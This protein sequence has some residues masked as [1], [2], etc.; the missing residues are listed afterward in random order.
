MSPIVNIFNK[1]SQFKKLFYI[2]L[3]IEYVNE[4]LDIIYLN[5]FNHF[6][7]LIFRMNTTS[8]HEGH[9]QHRSQ[10]LPIIRGKNALSNPKLLQMLDNTMTSK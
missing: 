1:K 7:F 9:K 5:Y 6:S 3:N 2:W 8:S 10:T 4:H